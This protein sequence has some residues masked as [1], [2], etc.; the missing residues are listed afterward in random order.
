MAKRRIIGIM[1]GNSMDAVDLVLT[2]FNA[3]NMH[4]IYALSQPYPLEQK[5]E[6]NEL[7]DKVIAQK[8]CAD[9]L[10]KNEEFLRIHE[11][12]VRGVADAVKL[13][14]QQHHI[15][16]KSID[17]IG[18]H[19]KTLD[20]NPPSRARITH[21]Q[22]FTTQMGSAQRLADLTG[23]PV[24]GD[25]RSA[26]IKKG[27]EGAPLAGPH[28][29]H[30]AQIEGDGIYINAGNTSNLAVIENKKV[31]ESWDIGP[32]NE[33]TDNFVL[34]ICG[35]MMDKNGHYG[36]KGKLL[37]SWLQFLFDQGRAFYEMEPPKSGD[38]AFYRTAE[39]WQKANE[40]F[41]VLHS[42]QQAFYDVIR[43]LEYFAAY[44]TVHALSRVHKNQATK[45]I[46]FGG[47][48]KN[49][50][51]WQ[52]F[53]NLLRSDG[54]VLP[55]HESLF[56]ELRRQAVHD[57]IVYSEYGTYMEARLFAELA[58]FYLDK[59]GW[60]LAEVENP[61]ILGRRKVPDGGPVDD[62]LSAAA[63]GWQKKKE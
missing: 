59:R 30:V 17:A 7:R 13:M 56:A 24:I 6:I 44:L 37:P 57:T 19:G 53:E 34:K 40:K 9:E 4:D 23:I 20:H 49:P 29:A 12:Y 58:E 1:T 63:R 5:K 15:D 52:S 50:L 22:A 61:L 11:R 14:L 32:F 18:F 38:P 54:Y 8:I 43:T 25:F 39:I 28:N 41:G 35:E 31:S 47:G 26:L 33:Y 3:G 60:P 46:L 51:V 10:I 21:T 16:P 36:A 48:W 27:Y 62:Y 42:K 45:L 55:E 2:E